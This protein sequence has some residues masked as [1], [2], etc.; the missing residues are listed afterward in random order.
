LAVD[1]HLYKGE[2]LDPLQTVFRVN[3][4]VLGSKSREKLG[5]ITDSAHAR[6]VRAPNADF[7]DRGPFVQLVFNTYLVALALFEFCITR[8]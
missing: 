1:L 3:P 6:T 7:P 8:G 2:G 5:T 4:E